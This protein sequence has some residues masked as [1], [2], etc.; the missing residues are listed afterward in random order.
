M[1]TGTHPATN[2]TNIFL[3]VTDLFSPKS[4]ISEQSVT[5][6]EAAPLWE[7]VSQNYLQK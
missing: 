1:V 3:L 5:E 2:P 4:N 7:V 6:S